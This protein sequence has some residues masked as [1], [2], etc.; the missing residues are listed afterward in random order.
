MSLRNVDG[1]S[2][3]ANSQ[4]RITRY[5][6]ILAFATVDYISRNGETPELS[7]V[8]GRTL[9]RTK[10]RARSVSAEELPTMNIFQPRVVTLVLELLTSNDAFVPRRSPS[11]VASTK[12]GRKGKIGDTVHPVAT[13]VVR[14]YLLRYHHREERYQESFGISNRPSGALV[15]PSLSSNLRSLPLDPG[16]T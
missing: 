8:I 14:A 4:F 9:P 12:E 13:P 1:N 5:S 3:I 6:R 2:Y 16:L 11:A 10:A 15:P 7:P